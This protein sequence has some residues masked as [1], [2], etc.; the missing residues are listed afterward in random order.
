LSLL[1]RSLARRLFGP[2]SARHNSRLD[3]E[4][5]P[6]R[7]TSPPVPPSTETTALQPAENTREPRPQPEPPQRVRMDTTDWREPGPQSVFRGRA[8]WDGGG[9]RSTST[10]TPRQ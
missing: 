3:I 1:W 9:C 5:P 2:T 7:E 4:R 6:A 8:H 10:P